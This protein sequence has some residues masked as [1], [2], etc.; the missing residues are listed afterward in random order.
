MY[1]PWFY[2]EADAA[3]GQRCF[4]ATPPKN[5]PSALTLSTEG[6]IPAG[7]MSFYVKTGRYASNALETLT[8]EEATAS[9]NKTQ[10]FSSEEWNYREAYVFTECETLKFRMNMHGEEEFGIRI[11]NICFPPPHFPIIFAGNDQISCKETNIELHEAYAYDC[12]TMYWTTEGDGLFD[13]NNMVNT[14]YY[15]GTQDFANGEVTLTLHASDS[16][17]STVNS[18]KVI[19]LDEVNL[20]GNII[21]D[22]IVN[23]YSNPVCHYSIE[24]QEGMHYLWQ[25]GPAEAGVIYALN[26]AVDILWNMDGNDTE[27]MLSVTTENNC[28]VE[29]VTKRIRLVNNATSEWPSIKFELFPN[30]TD[31]KVNLVVG[32]M[33][34]GK[35]VVEVY[36][37]LGERMMAKNIGRLLQ[38]ETISLDLSHL[39]SGLY[40]VKLSTENGS[41]SKKVSVR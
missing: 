38:G 18:M 3:E 5:K 8:I 34:Q 31:G 11:D 15:P 25:L 12:D 37:L 26:N 32:E 20:E 13:N 14:H 28:Q 40:I 24:P 19:L 35:A 16:I 7:K 27:V 6:Y 33:L 4:E 21:G 1:Y 39:V 10:T 23:K 41:C 17:H 30:P 2:T 36:N 29:P 9:G 22:S